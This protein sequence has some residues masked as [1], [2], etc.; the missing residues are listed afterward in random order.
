MSVEGLLGTDDV[1]TAALLQA[2]R[3]WYRGAWL[4]RWPKATAI[5]GHRDLHS[6]AC[7]GDAVY[8]L[9][10]ASTLAGPDPGRNPVAAL[11]LDDIGRVVAEHTMSARADYLVHDD[12]PVENVTQL[13]QTG[14]QGAV[15]EALRNAAAVA[16]VV[17]I[18]GGSIA[19]ASDMELARR[20][21]LEVASYNRHAGVNEANE[22]A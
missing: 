20:E 4:S 21:A 13:W 18:T 5:V 6:T 14:N 19:Y 22:R 8:Q 17:G 12:A 11:P 3:D 1:P 7:P 2:F 9:I 15:I 16:G 10:R